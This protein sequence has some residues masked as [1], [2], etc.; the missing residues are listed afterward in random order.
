MYT[1][2]IV[3]SMECAGHPIMHDIRAVIELTRWFGFLKP[4]TR[5]LR[6]GVSSWKWED[7][8]F[9]PPDWIDEMMEAKRQKMI[10]EYEDKNKG[11]LRS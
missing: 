11:I 1:S 7:T 3:K 10:W 9:F 4:H 2:A 6:G 5:I 8:G